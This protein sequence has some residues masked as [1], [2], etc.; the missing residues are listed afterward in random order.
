[1]D[2]T[3]AKPAMGNVACMHAMCGYLLSCTACCTAH[4]AYYSHGGKIA[5]GLSKT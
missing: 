5:A 2:Q 4:I 3:K 1:M